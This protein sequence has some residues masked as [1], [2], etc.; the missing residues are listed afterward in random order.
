MLG[1]MLVLFWLFLFLRARAAA[2]S[3]WLIK[4]SPD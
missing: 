4:T 1:D 3:A 2:L